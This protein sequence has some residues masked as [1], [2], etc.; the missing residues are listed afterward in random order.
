[1]KKHI[2]ILSS[3]IFL[4]LP[5]CFE[6]SQAKDDL[7]K[8]AVAA[9][10][11]TDCAHD[12][13]TFRCVEVLKNYDGDTLT[14]N[15]PNVPALIGKKISVRVHGIDTPE[16]K[17][18][19]QCEKEAGRMARNLVTSTLKNAKSIELHNVQR[20][21]Y[22]RILADVMVDGR[23]LKDVLLKNNLAYAYDGGTKQHPDWCKS[24]RQPASK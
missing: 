14:V 18:K 17:T 8:P 15:I 24:L 21:K 12:D 7:Q 16:V 9:V 20:D 6:S 13:K 19:N 1:M 5:A 11:N 23:S 2:Q 4:T 3:L 22:F 10:A